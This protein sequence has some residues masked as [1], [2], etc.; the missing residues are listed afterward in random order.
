MSGDAGVKRRRAPTMPSLW[1]KRVGALALLALGAYSFLGRSRD[2]KVTAP[3]TKNLKIY[4]YEMSVR[5]M[6]A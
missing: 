1:L 6:V 4:I 5:A 3:S 2:L